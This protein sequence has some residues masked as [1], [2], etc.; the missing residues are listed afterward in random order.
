MH[1]LS[2]ELKFQLR[3][4]IIKNLKDNIAVQIT[5]DYKIRY[6]EPSNNKFFELKELQMYVGGYIEVYPEQVLRETILFVDEEGLLK[7][8]PY[9]QLAKDL[10][11]ID[12][13]GDIL[14]VPNNLMNDDGDDE[15]E[16]NN[17]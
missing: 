15:D 13:V 16:R 2:T 3:R 7:N 9:N 10:F 8:K 1:K 17:A 12:L 11:G 5:D 4:K 6:V 14:F